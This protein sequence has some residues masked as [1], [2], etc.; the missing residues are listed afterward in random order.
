[1]GVAATLKH[2]PGHG[3]TADDSHAMLP[4]VAANAAEL[5]ARDLVPFARVIAAGDASLVLGAHVVAEAFDRERPAT[6]SRAVMTDLLRG[7]L[8]FRGVA[9]TDCLEMDAIAKNAGTVNGAVQALAAGADLVLISH[10]LELARSAVEAIVAAVEGGTLPRARLV[11]AHERVLAL[12]E[13]MARA[14]AYADDV[15]EG[16]PLEAARRAVTAV[17]GEPRLRDGKPVT[18]ISFEGRARDAAAASGA[19]GAAAAPS[20]SAALRRRGRKSEIMRVPLEPDGDDLD[21]L[22]EHVPALGDRDFVVIARDAHLHAR[23]RDA[24][25]RILAAAPAAT[26]V[27]ARAPFDALLWPQARTVLCIY[28]D[29]EISLDGCADV[30]HGTVAARGVLPVRL[31]RDAAVR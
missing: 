16:A 18:V 25:T 28:G 6:L 12:R 8:G 4:H 1:V 3:S 29:G 23:Q 22:L 26:V 9:M 13:R 30:L 2:F 20:L 24:V 15:D 21:L 10:H 7:E 11:E 5:R 19:R 31:A 27:S 14:Q 17:R